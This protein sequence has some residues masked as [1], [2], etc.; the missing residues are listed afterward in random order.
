M[1]IALTGATGNMGR[2]ALLEL[3]KLEIVDKI[4]ILVSP[5]SKK[6][7]EMVINRCKQ[8][9]N[10]V[11]VVYGNISNFEDCKRLIEG[12]NYIFHMAAVI[13]PKADKFP[14]RAIDCNEKGTSNLIKAIAE[15]TPQPKFVH[16]S[17]V[18]LYGNRN[19]LCPWAQVGDPLLVS[20]LDVYSV[21]KLRAE[22]MVM[23]SG[24]EN[25]AV[26]RQSAMLHPNM[27]KDNMS[28]GLMFHTCFNAPL[29][30]VT[31]HDS[32]VLIANIVLRDSKED[33]GNKFWKHCFNIGANNTNQI[34]GY[35][36]LNDGFKLIGGT[37]KHFFKPNFNATRNFHG[38]WFYDGNKLNDLF[39]YVSQ[40]LE[41]YW[42]QIAKKYWYYKFGKIVPKSMISK[43]TIQKLF[44]DNNSPA[45]WYKTGDTA[46]LTAF[47]GSKEEYERVSKN[48]SEFNLIVENKSP[49]GDKIDFNK[50]K[51][52]K[53]AVLINYGYD[54]TKPDSEIT[55]QDLIDVA[56]M[57][58]GKLLSKSFETGNIYNKVKWL[59]Q[60]GNEFEATPYSVLRAGHWNNSCYHTF[61]WD[62]DRLSKK[63][64]IYAQIWN[65]SHSENE[66]Y[67]YYLDEKLNPQ[68]KINS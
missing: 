65:T 28:D 9:K 14:Q 1:K 7:G 63:D 32:G 24:L 23:E 30:W 13:P 62:F 6:R 40:N 38:V 57:H 25:W 22:F 2:E 67:L 66:N 55:K 60:D 18:A 21:T 19:Y 68:I 53:N 37:A 59:D 12:T 5:T 29:E 64:K 35:E 26:L 27:L 50:L 42:K 3:S 20:P 33:L 56:T 46:K 10:K 41:D 16:T 34:T 31:S 43:F 48:W 61:T 39:D 58:G 11:E 4:K 8:N 51:D 52:R 36:T 54:Y 47:F 17:T 15:V 44:K 49:N 45:Y